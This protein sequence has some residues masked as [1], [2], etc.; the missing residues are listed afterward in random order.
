MDCIKCS[1]AG[2]Y[3]YPPCPHRRSDINGRRPNITEAGQA[4][5]GTL[6]GKT[7]LRTE[8]KIRLQILF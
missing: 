5:A 8:K 6:S 7:C 3:V 4:S 1:T 2:V